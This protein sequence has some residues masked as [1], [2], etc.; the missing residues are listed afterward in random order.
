MINYV[1]LIIH[2]K[3]FG[4]FIAVPLETL[5]S[6]L[7]VT[8]AHATVVMVVVCSCIISAVHIVLSS[9]QAVVHHLP[10]V[11]PQQVA[12]VA[13]DGEVKLM[14][15]DVVLLHLITTKQHVNNHSK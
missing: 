13:C 3:F 10:M 4:L 2:F 9:K 6:P 12:S 5:V 11:L 15:I 1:S 7:L 14:C 8:L